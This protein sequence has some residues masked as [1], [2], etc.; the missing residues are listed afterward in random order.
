MGTILLS[1]YLPE[2]IVP[3]GQLTGWKISCAKTLSKE[4]RNNQSHRPQ[5]Y[6]VLGFGLS[7]MYHHKTLLLVH[8]AFILQMRATRVCLEQ[9]FSRSQSVSSA[10][11][12]KV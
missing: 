4:I 3:S 8:F 9:S 5:E 11:Q 2:E 10:L 1:S 6:L 7:H 12:T